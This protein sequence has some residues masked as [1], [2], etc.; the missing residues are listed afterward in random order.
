MR[1]SIFLGL[2]NIET[3][4]STLC[5]VVEFGFFKI[6]QFVPKTLFNSPME[7]SA[8]TFS[9]NRFESYLIFILN[10]LLYAFLLNGT[11]ITEYL[12]YPVLLLQFHLA[13]FSA[14]NTAN[15]KEVNSF[16]S[17]RNRMDFSVRKINKK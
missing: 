14:L 1:T 5:W 17:R 13:L 6:C 2:Y 15:F 4:P 16:F 12:L 10:H 7:R 9:S 11:S 3:I 8:E